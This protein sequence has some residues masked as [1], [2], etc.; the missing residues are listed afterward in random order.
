MRRDVYLLQAD[1]VME[2]RYAGDADLTV[3]FDV[4][5]LVLGDLDL[6]EET[7]RRDEELEQ[8][9]KDSEHDEQKRV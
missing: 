3:T 1:T 4:R 5:P 6:I 9:E 7:R 8:Q 2:I